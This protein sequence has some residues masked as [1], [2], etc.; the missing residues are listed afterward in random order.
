M[1]QEDGGSLVKSPIQNQ[2]DES[3]KESDNLQDKTVN[4][5]VIKQ[6]VNSLFILCFTNI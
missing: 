6:F 1:T 5:D 4:I 3:L 2:E